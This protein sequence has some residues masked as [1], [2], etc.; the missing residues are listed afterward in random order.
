MS[1]LTQQQVADVLGL[2][3]STYAYYESGKTTPDIKSVNKLLK[4]FNISYY[5]LMDEPDPNAVS[6]SDSDAQEDEED[7]LH[8]YD[9]SKLEKRLVIYFRVLSPN[10][11]KDLLNSISPETF[12]GRK[13]RKYSEDDED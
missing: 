8:I 10:Q 3:R 9:L 5:E 1:G 7:K 2:D 4:I 12:E 13:K 6:V 11:Q